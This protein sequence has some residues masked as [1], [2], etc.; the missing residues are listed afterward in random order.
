[1]RNAL[2]FP[3]LALVAAPLACGSSSDS[4]NPADT[5]PSSDAGNDVAS[6]APA[7]SGPKSPFTVACTDA[8]SDVLVAPTGLPAFDPSHRGDVVRCAFDRALASTDV[9]ALAATEAFKMNEPAPAGVKMWKIAYRTTRPGDKDALGTAWI[10]APD[11]PLDGAQPMVVF[12]HGTRGAAPACTESSR[13]ELT[14]DEVVL[15]L[16]MAAHGYW[17]MAPDYAGADFAQLPPGYLYAEDEARSVLDSTRSMKTLVP[18]GS[19]TDSVLAIG[20]SQGGHVVLATQAFAKTYGLAG[21]LDGVIAFAPP[22]F[23]AKSYGAIPSPLVGLTTKDDAYTIGYAMLYLYTHGEL[24]DGPGGGVAM[25][26]ASKRDA[27]KTMFTTQCDYGPPVMA[28]GATPSDFFD[29]AWVTSVGNCAIADSGCDTDP[30]K[31]WEARFKADRP[32]IDATQAP[33]VIWEGGNDTT[34]PKDR[35][36]CGVDKIN[37]DLTAAGSAATWKLT[38]CGDATADHGGVVKDNTEWALQWIAAHAKGTAIPTCAGWDTIG[39]PVC[40]TPPSNTD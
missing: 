34:V 2:L 38:T 20:H 25:Y 6:D 8:L 21:K 36:A 10:F 9:D 29:S 12:A 7:D 31:T 39:S 11:K 23:V 40:A 27:I 19:L 3:L 32:A 5:G 4:T 22:W 30:A 17:V 15:P 35:V 13:P 33:I 28:L 16:E 26:Q 24:L 18:A 14:D 1:M 37:A